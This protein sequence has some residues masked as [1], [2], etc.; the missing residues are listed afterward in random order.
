MPFVIVLIGLGIELTPAHDLYTGPLLTAMPALASL[1]MGPLG[2]LSA[3]AG[4][5][6]VSLTTATLHD[7]WGGTQIYSNLLGLLVVSVASVTTSNAVR[8]R[9]QSE[10]DQVRRIAAAAQEV[11]LRPV[12][13]CLGPVRAA[14]MYLAAE[15]GAQ[16]GGDLYE[17]VQTPYGVRVIV[18]DVRGKGLDAV[19]SAA[20]VL[21]AF[22][23]AAHYEDELVAVMN[24]CSAA[25]RREHAG[26][27]TAVGAGGDDPDLVEGFV[28]ALVAQVPDEPVV[29]VVNCGHPPPLVLRG[30][31]VHA[32]ASASPLPPLGLEEFA[33]GLPAKVESHPFVPG[34]LLLLYTDGVIEARN[35]DKDFFAL[36]EAMQAVDTR[37]PRE[38]LEQLHQR[39]LHHTSGHLT[40]DTAMIALERDGT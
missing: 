29:E 39:L 6:G 31:G 14:S 22:R 7:A 25:L 18:G 26:P 19:R 20:A 28:T 30:A 15:R 1:T 3:A 27:D 21:S 37:T 32:L 13:D 34:D 5:L 2:T 35:R 9:R 36:P 12:P 17:A 38:F 40:D 10:L 16:I 4:A 8:T 11:I 33:T 24:H 23:E